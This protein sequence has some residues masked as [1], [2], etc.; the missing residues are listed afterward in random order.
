MI[1]ME[2]LK[3]HVLETLVIWNNSHN[4]STSRV[5]TP[6]RS[7]VEMDREFGFEINVKTYGTMRSVT[8]AAASGPADCQLF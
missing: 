5:Y 8:A 3:K 7:R 2:I 4:L 6:A 1:D